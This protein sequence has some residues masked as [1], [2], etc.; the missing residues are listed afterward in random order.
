MNAIIRLNPNKNYITLNHNGQFL[1]A[2][3]AP[4]LRSINEILYNN[5][6][7]VAYIGQFDFGVD[8]DYFSF[9]EALAELG[10]DMNLV[11]VE[12]IVGEEIR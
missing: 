5:N 8:E 9:S 12:F 10:M 4:T 6:G 7:M 1:R 11:D 2:S 3:V